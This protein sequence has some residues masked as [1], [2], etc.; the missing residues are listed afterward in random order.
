MLL[1]VQVRKREK[2]QLRD[3]EKGSIEGR[4]EERKESRPG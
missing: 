3:L 2:A 4:K 1:Q